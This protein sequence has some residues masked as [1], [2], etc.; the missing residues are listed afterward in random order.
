MFRRIAALLMVAVVFAACSG[1]TPATPTPQVTATAAPTPTPIDVPKAFLPQIVAA[2][3]GKLA[4]TGTLDLGSQT[5]PL[6]GSVTYVGGDSDQ[7][8]TIALGGTPSTTYSIRKAGS[9]YTKNGDGPWLPDAA[10]PA[11]GK[12]LSTVFRSLASLTDAGTETKGGVELHRLEM[13]AGTVLDPAIIGLTA[14]GITDAKLSLVFYAEADGTPAIVSLT[15]T[16][17][18]SGQPARMVMDMRFVQIG[19]SLAI[20]IPAH[21]WTTFAST[22]FHYL[23]DFPDDWDVSTTDKTF[24]RFAS[25]G[26]SFALATRAKTNGATLNDIAKA[27]IA[28]N[29]KSSLVLVKNESYKVAGQQA[30]FITYGATL[31]GKKYAAYEVIVVNGAYWY[32]MVWLSPAASA[33]A[34]LVTAKLMISTFAF[35]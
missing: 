30:R 16:W 26:E 1:Q 5:G 21:V 34:D 2:T 3:S 19:G 27:E 7:T 33:A 15:A 29:K 25:P 28:V 22:R 31:S 24:D 9:G 12:D 8:L 11:A 32:G 18:Q 10:K 35:S 23:M 4:I 14:A 20:T 6:S 13:P 17:T